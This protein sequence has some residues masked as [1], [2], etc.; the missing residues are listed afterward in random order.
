MKFRK[1]PEGKR[2]PAFPRA[3]RRGLL[4][5][6]SAYCSELLLKHPP[7]WVAKDARLGWLLPSLKLGYKDIT[8]SFLGGWYIKSHESGG[9]GCKLCSTSSVTFK[10]GI[11]VI[12]TSI[13]SHEC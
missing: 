2:E 6:E 8:L 10:M 13:S 5:N 11:L 7:H 12:S 9:P 3:E 1:H 4:K